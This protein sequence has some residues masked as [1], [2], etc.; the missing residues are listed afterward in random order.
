MVPWGGLSWEALVGIPSGGNKTQVIHPPCVPGEGDE[1]LGK[2]GA[3]ALLHVS[4][5][6]FQGLWRKQP[7]L[8]SAGT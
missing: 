8:S 7:T 2:D 6:A 5:N 4:F 3:I 1:Q